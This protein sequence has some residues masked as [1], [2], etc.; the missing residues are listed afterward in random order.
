MENKPASKGINRFFLARLGYYLLAFAISAFLAKAASVMVLAH[1]PAIPHDYAALIRN[2]LLVA[3]VFA[4]YA[5]LVRV[6]EKRPA[7]EVGVV[8]GVPQFVA[9]ALLGIALI[10]LA[11]GV[12]W[13][14]GSA[15]FSVGHGARDLLRAFA[16]PTV[17]ALLEELVFRVILFAVL[18]QI[19]GTGAAIILSAGLFGLAHAANP[20][21]SP[22]AISSLAVGLG[23][24][25]ALAYSLTRNIGLPAG[26]HMGWNFAQAFLFGAK[27]SGLDEP[28]SLF[29]VRLA[30]PDWLTGGGFGI[31]GSVFTAA[32]CLAASIVLLVMVVRRD[33]WQRRR[34]R[35][36]AR[37]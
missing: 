5:L 30:G 17:V 35:L 36:S 11:F 3:V 34:F 37:P 8:S 10:A 16:L 23:V 26:V 1:T 29:N 7:T 6:V 21:A 27:V 2:G 9:G 18:E 14:V 12:L 28:S 4:F 19:T 22:V 15:Q 24:L 32:I 25:L 33:H 13:I 31:E 20:G